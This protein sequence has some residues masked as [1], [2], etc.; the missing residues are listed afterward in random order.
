VDHEEDNEFYDLQDQEEDYEN[1]DED[2]IE[3]YNDSNKQL[4][5]SPTSVERE[6]EDIA[7]LMN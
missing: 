2:L 1:E 3:S 4:V 6:P 5:I 7:D